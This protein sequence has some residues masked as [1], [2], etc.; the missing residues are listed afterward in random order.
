[1]TIAFPTD[2]RVLLLKISR[3]DELAFHELYMQTSPQLYGVALRLMKRRD[4]AEEVIQEVFLTLWHAADQYDLARGSV[5]TWL[6]T[7]TRNRCID[8]LRRQPAHSVEIQ[9]QHLADD[10][11]D[12]LHSALSQADL[13]VLAEC[14]ES[15]NPQQ[16][17]CLALAYYDGLTH[18]EVAH[19]L[20]VPL[21][22]AKTWIRRGLDF[23]K[24][25]MG[26]AE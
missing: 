24:K 4:L 11:T 22:S 19:Q 18:Q 8:R 17:H 7:I 20:D 26:A 14:F 9:E 21:G 5:R 16:R 15:L 3:G 10:R 6:S 13:H 23:L 12:P 1:M 25:C 2:E